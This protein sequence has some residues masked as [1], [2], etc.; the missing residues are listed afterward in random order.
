MA[1]HIW[2][3][4]AV[5]CCPQAFGALDNCH[6]PV[7][8]PKENA[9]DYYN[10]KGWYSVLLLALV[11]HNYTNYTNLGYPGRCHG[12]HVLQNYILSRAIRGPAFQSPTI[13][14][15]TSLLPRVALCDQAFPL[16]PNL[17]KLFPGS[18]HTPAESNFNYGL[19]KT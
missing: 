19:S 12:A 10:Y 15:G 16:I 8:P 13:C 4:C 9:I 7:S 1:D 17:M 14:V 18:S 2:E 5:A 6:F 3:F 11:D